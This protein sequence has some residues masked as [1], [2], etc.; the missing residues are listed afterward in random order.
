MQDKINQPFDVLIIGGGIN[1]CG[2]AR[3]AVGRG[4][5]VLLCESNDLGG[6][7][8]SASTKLIHGGLRYLE[9]YKFRLVREALK[10]REVLWRMAPHIVWPLRFVLPHHKGLRPQW[11]LRLGLF[12]YDHLG[13]RKLLPASKRVNLTDGPEGAPLK[14]DYSTGFEYSDCWVEDSRFVVLNAM[15]AAERGADI[16]TRTAAVS[17]KWVDGLWQVGLQDKTTGE[18]ENVSARLIVNA[19]GPWVD[20]VLKTV[21]GKNDASN[22]RLVRGSHIVVAKKFEHEKCYI[23]QNA[24]DRIIFAIPYEQDYTLIGT[25]DVEHGAIDGKPQITAEEISY[26]CEMASAYFNEPVQEQDVVWTYSGVRPLYDD[27]ASAAQEATRDYV[28]RKDPASGAGTLIDVFGGKI[29]TYRKLAEAMMEE[30]ES[31]IGKKGKAWTENS[32]LPGG[33]FAIS[34]RDGLAEQIVSDYPFIEPGHASRLVR[35]YGTRALQIL[36]DCNSID[37]LGK[38]FAVNLYQREVDYLE[39]CEWARSAEDV[40]FRRSKLGIKASKSEVEALQRYFDEREV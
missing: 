11:L 38:R 34:D 10:E 26:L 14:N 32:T 7:T 9:H 2:I 29:T 12:F 22:V 33:D 5:S 17:A 39:S 15:D 24:D 13:G 20:E 18:T 4:Y 30:I 35:A 23:F 28:L 16:R 1:G 31:S 3:D 21:F 40:L 27:G 25:T 36:A 37:D 6:G 8:S 19:A